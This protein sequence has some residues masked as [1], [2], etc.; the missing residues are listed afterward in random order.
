MLPILEITG[1]LNMIGYGLATIGPGI[2]QGLAAASGEPQQVSVS[3]D[4]LYSVWMAWV[5]QR[6]NG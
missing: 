4:W 6:R 3:T 2:G 5:C 1:S